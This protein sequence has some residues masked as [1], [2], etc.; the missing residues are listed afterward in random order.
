MDAGTIGGSVI[1]LGSDGRIVQSGGAI[2]GD[3]QYASSRYSPSRGFDLHGG[4]IAGSIVSSDGANVRIDGGTVGGDVQVTSGPVYH[5][6]FQM[7]GGSIAGA[8]DASGAAHAR[9]L[10]GSIAGSVT[11]RDDASLDAVSDAL[12]S[13]LFARDAAFLRV[14]GV[15]DA[16]YGPIAES[17]GTI[18][19]QRKD[20][21]PFA[22]PFERDA[23]A[24]IVLAAP[25]A[26]A[27]ASALT[28]AGVV[29]GLAS[30]RR[31]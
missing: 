6:A 7:E 4:S 22:V 2:L 13:G 20:G 31:A 23:G 9:I 3:V 16:P 1:A 5:I 19:G 18:T 11:A 12:G 21:T 30:R 8:F 25:E 28:A 14:Y 24:T 17:A 15:F 27:V 10:G 26:D 29:A